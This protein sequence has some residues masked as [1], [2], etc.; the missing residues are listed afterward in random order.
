[1]SKK[2][3]IVSK[4]YD[5]NVENIV[6][7]LDKKFEKMTNDSS[8]VDAENVYILEEII[9]EFE[10]SFNFLSLKPEVDDDD[11]DDYNDD[12]DDDDYYDDDDE[13]EREQERNEQYMFNL[14]QKV[15][16]I[17]YASKNIKDKKKIIAGYKRFIDARD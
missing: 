2:I 8:T 7:S 4:A 17:Y 1:M 11:Y 16:D 13:W 10:P 9:R 3:R 6:A 12:D 15:M 5:S 14:S